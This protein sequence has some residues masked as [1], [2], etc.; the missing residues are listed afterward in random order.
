MD[1]DQKARPLRRSDEAPYWVGMLLGL[2]I[3]LGIARSLA[4]S[5]W[6]SNHGI[7]TALDAALFVVGL[8]VLIIRRPV[9]NGERRYSVPHAVG[10]AVVVLVGPTIVMVAA[11]GLLHLLQR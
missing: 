7:V 6:P 3:A 9:R 8:T 10:L 5:L 2:C 1:S 11:V 4:T